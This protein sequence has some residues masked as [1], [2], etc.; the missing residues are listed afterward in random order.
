MIDRKHAEAEIA[1]LAGLDNFT[2]SEARSKATDELVLALMAAETEIIATVVINEWLH[3]QREVPKP[4]DLRALVWTEN[5]KRLPDPIE[6]MRYEDAKR[7]GYCKMCQRFGFHGGHLGGP[8][9]C[10]W[11]VCTCP[12]GNADAAA[13]V[14]DA[15]IAREKLLKLKGNPQGTM[16]DTI[17]RN[18]RKLVNEIYNGEF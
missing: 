8:K 17:D 10:E 12:A 16:L 5:E 15:N 3:T 11:K 18:K 14:A 7:S 13:K 1:R 6:Q 2:P 4:A 9:A